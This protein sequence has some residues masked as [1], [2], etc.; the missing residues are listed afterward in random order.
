VHRSVDRACPKTLS[1]E[2][3]LEIDQVGGPDLVGPFVAEQ[4]NHV[5]LDERRSVYQPLC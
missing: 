3:C 4:W 2:I 5:I 1:A